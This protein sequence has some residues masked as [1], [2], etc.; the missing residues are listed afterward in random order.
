MILPSLQVQQEFEKERGT[1]INPCLLS[2]CYIQGALGCELEA[3]LLFRD[4]SHSCAWHLPMDI[5]TRSALRG[6]EQLWARGWGCWAPR[7]AEAAQGRVRRVLGD[8]AGSWGTMVIWR[9][10]GGEGTLGPKTHKLRRQQWLAQPRTEWR[11]CGGRGRTSTAMGTGLG[12]AEPL[13][14]VSTEECGY[15]GNST[16]SGHSWLEG[17]RGS[18]GK[19]PQQSDL[20]DCPACEVDWGDSGSM[21]TGRHL[22]MRF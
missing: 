10:D 15:G 11:V 17:R 1:K 18:S 20:G 5:S 9:G 4:Q 6:T 16:L 2:L 21:C 14:Y 7:T 19:R 8:R 22:Q 12:E 3:C 13:Q